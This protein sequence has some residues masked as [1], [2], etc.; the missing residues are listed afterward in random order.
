MIRL[1]RA[2]AWLR[3]RLLVNGLTRSRRR[4]DIERLSRALSVGLGILAGVAVFAIAG[5][6]AA[7][8]FSAAWRASADNIA[9]RALLIA[10]RALLGG[11][12]AVIVLGPIVR[13][14]HGSASG[15]TRFALLP[16]PRTRMHLVEVLSGLTDPWLLLVLPALTALPAGFL[17]SGKVV[18]AIVSFAG[19]VLVAAALA[20]LGCTLAFGAHLLLRNRRRGEML[21]FVFVA[22]LMVLGMVPS[23]L[24]RRHE[25][26][27]TDLAGRGG[28]ALRWA[29]VLPSEQYARAVELSF[30]DR[31]ARAAGPLALLGGWSAIFYGLS[32]L[33]YRRLLE[34]PA[35]E[36]S[37]RAAGRLRYGMVRVPGLSSA[38]SAVAVAEIRLVLR[39]VRGRTAVLLTP[40]SMALL[41]FVF[42]HA[43]TPTGSEPFAA[44]GTFWMACLAVSFSMLAVQ[45]FLLN[46]FAIDRGGLQLTFLSPVSDEEMVRGK[47]VAGLL[48][49]AATALLCLLALAIVVPRREP[50]LWSAVFLGGLAAQALMAPVAAVLSAWLP[51]TSDLNRLGSAGNPHA[52]ASVGGAFVALGFAVPPVI[53]GIGVHMLSRSPAIVFM[54]LVVWAAAC[55]VLSSVLLRLAGRAVGSR[56]ENLMFVAMGR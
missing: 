45:P 38:A 55:G 7:V 2:F 49:W 44:S 5:V 54:A 53:L 52:A 10:A 3:W 4:D 20:A 40:P 24:A 27:T 31:P 1:A 35:G 33:A 22:G 46:Q 41:G 39:S 21:T 56:R 11:A 13:S 29:R 30:E 37:R 16:V 15:Y 9:A 23:I 42:T 26:A 8:A 12:T 6:L 36:S 43:R 34:S 47:A 19:G 48:L 25:A 18:P 14:L 28:T 32:W 51:R 50:L 17:L